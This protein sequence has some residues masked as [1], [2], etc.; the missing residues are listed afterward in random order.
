MGQQIIQQPDG[1]YA[2]WSSVVD[3]FVLI[4]ATPEEIVEHWLAEEATRLRSRVAEIVQQLNEGKRPYLQFQMSWPE[5]LKTYRD[6]HGREFSL[7]VARRA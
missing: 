4:D 1:K 7:E 2:L 3:A 5:A 6:I